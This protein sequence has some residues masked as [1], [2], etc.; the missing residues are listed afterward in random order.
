MSCGKNLETRQEKSQK[1]N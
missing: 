1:K